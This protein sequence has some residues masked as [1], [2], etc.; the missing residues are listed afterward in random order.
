MTD[1]FRALC[2][3]DAA[4][5]GEPLSDVEW[6]HALG[7]DVR[8]VRRWRRGENR[9][10]GAAAAVINGL[11]IALRDAQ[12]DAVATRCVLVELRTLGDLGL[13]GWVVRKTRKGTL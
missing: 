7:T 13:A 6:A 9:P 12:G 3:A 11:S 1:N 5:P 2:L 4:A 8:T 10:T